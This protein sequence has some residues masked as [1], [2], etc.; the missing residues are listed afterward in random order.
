MRTSHTILA[1]ALGLLL[2]SSALAQEA[3]SAAFSGL[4][5]ESY[6]QVSL[7]P[8]EDGGGVVITGDLTGL[9]P[10]EHG[11]HIHETGTCDAASKFE[12]AGGHFNPTAHEHGKENP[13]GPHAGDF[14]NITVA[15]DGTASVN[16][17]QATAALNTEGLLDADGSALMI[18]ADPDD[19]STDPSGNSGDRI[20]C[21]V[22]APQP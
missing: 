14:D 9:P 22:I 5:G 16:I 10:G 8:T 15:A 18:H 2:A 21:A 3:A 4:G 7:V 6:G 19:Y 13:Q 11:F 17:T 12:S 20:A 1:S